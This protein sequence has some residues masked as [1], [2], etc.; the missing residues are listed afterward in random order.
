MREITGNIEVA[1]SGI[2]NPPGCIVSRSVESPGKLSKLADLTSFCLMKPRAY[3]ACEEQERLSESS[4]NRSFAAMAMFEGH[5]GFW[6]TSN[7]D[8]RWNVDDCRSMLRTDSDVKSCQQSAKP[9]K[10]LGER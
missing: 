2:E 5:V 6:G 4:D 1:K 8:S 10:M 3:I 7:S 9:N